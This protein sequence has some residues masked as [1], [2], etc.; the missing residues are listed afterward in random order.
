[1]GAKEGDLTNFEGDLK[2]VEEGALKKED[3]DESK[4]SEDE[5][6]GPLVA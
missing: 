6:E 2:E 4:N 1:M 5:D 3:D